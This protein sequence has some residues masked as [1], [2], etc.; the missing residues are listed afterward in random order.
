MAGMW[1]TAAKYAAFAAVCIAGLALLITTMANGVRGDSAE[2]RADF[3][4]ASGLRPGDDVRA[5][6]VKVGRVEKIE[7]HGT[8][9]RVTFSLST[10]QPMTTSTTLTL[11]YQSLLGQRYVA[12]G[13]GEKAGVAV[14]PGGL[15]PLERT[16]P[17]FD[18]TAL[19]NGFQPL[20]STLKPEEVNKLSA[21]IIAVLQGEGGTVENMLAETAELTN[22]LADA[23]TTVDQVLANLTPVL[24]NLARNGD[25]VD[26]T[27]EELRALGEGLA[28]QRAVIGGSLEG[29]QRLSAQMADLIEETRPSVD[30]N[31]E[32]IK[33]FARI[34]VEKRQSINSLFASMPDGGLSLARAFSDGTWLNIY[35]CHMSAV[36]AGQDIQVD[37][38]ESSN[39]AA[40]R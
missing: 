40:C 27:I 37:V 36:I 11:R 15:V 39:S 33:E 24:E 14:P 23:D 7:L 3:S 9:A 29:T 22:R 32:A 38:G 35:L 20:F 10:D 5:A 8:A 1:G 17:G 6:G 30:R 34:S 18:L 4:N 25:Q 12:M 13:R 16:D 19:L 26:A 28:E 21:S 31:I 2:F